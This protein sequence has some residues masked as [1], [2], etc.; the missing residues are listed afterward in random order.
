MK[1]RI[2]KLNII[3]PWELGTEKAI[4]VNIVDEYGG[5]Y[6]IF[7]PDRLTA[8]ETRINYLIGEPREDK[9]LDLFSNDTQGTI[10]LNLV[11]STEINAE[12]FKNYRLEKFRGN[13]L[14]GEVIF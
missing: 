11:Y 10:P 7:L 14:L 2:G 12:N 8:N 13:F 5:Q 6:L 3:E 4:N 1:T 9:S